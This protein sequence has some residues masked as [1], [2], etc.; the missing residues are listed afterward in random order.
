MLCIAFLAIFIQF[1]IVGDI[2]KIREINLLKDFRVFLKILILGGS[3]KEFLLV[4]DFSYSHRHCLTIF[5]V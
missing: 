1:K 4:D 2:L 3:L 5:N